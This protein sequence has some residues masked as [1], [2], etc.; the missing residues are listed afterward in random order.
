MSRFALGLG[1]SLIAGTSVLLTLAIVTRKALRASATRR[2]EALRVEAQPLL[3]TITSGRRLP[4]G[5]RPRVIAEVERLA[6]EA[7][8]TVRGEAAG[9]LVAYLRG[10]DVV[11]RA[12]R[13]L[14]GRGRVRRARAAETLGTLRAA[15][16]VQPLIGALADRSEE[17]RHVA[18][19]AL[20]KIGGVEAA[21][22]LLGALDG[23]RRL[24]AGQ[25]SRALVAMGGAAIPAARA[26]LRTDD[27]TAGYVAAQLLG[28]LEALEAVPELELAMVSDRPVEVRV[29]A[30]RALGRIGAP[31]AAPTLLAACAVDEPEPLRAAA[32]A[33]LGAV[34]DASALEPLQALVEEPG[35]AVP[36]AAAHA[37]VRL[38]FEGRAALVAHVAAGDAAAG[39]AA[40]ALALGEIGS[41]ARRASA[42]RRGRT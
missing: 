35:Y 27:A 29:E 19:R 9:E 2:R 14:S 3:V 32:A 20:G 12:L 37:L 28:H 5:I 21:A 16:A 40:E 7:L 1:I 8:R 24:H 34:G 26:A 30:A 18:A 41:E 4:S 22:A 36:H 13:R 17:V 6:L 11:P 31:S 25:V 23:H 15:D 39:H 10:S 33:S 38:G 42:G